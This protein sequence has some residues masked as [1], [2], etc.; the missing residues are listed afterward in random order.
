MSPPTPTASRPPS[1][2][3][4]LLR[5][6]LGSGR[7]PLA[8][9][10]GRESL[11]RG[12]EASLTSPLRRPFRGRGT[13]PERARRTPRSLSSWSRPQ[14]AGSA[15]AAPGSWPIA[16]PVSLASGRFGSARGPSPDR[17]Q[18]DACAATT[19]AALELTGRWACREATEV[20][21]RPDVRRGSGSEE[22][23]PGGRA[24]GGH[25][26]RRRRP[27]SPPG[28]GH[29]RAGA[30][31]PPRQAS[32]GVELRGARTH[33]RFTRNVGSIPHRAEATRAARTTDVAVG[34][35]PIILR[36]ESPSRR[37]LALDPGAS[38]CRRACM[39]GFGPDAVSFG[40]SRLVL[41]HR[42]FRL[43]SPRT[44]RPDSAD[45]CSAFTR[46]L[47]GRAS[48]RSPGSES[49]R[50][51]ELSARPPAVR[52]HRGTSG[53]F[54]RLVAATPS[55]E[56]WGARRPTRSTPGQR[57]TH[58]ASRLESLACGGL[59]RRV[60]RR[61]R[62]AED[63]SKMSG[64]P[65]HRLVSGRQEADPIG[66]HAVWSARRLAPRRTLGLAPRPCTVRRPR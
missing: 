65:A 59:C 14:P 17:S 10:H 64:P 36:E 48:L 12:A 33:A 30:E 38:P 3:S 61:P 52:R 58:A 63:A 23:A 55:V 37:H 9:E 41:E 66:S 7:M 13:R 47:L 29:D 39:T 19:P 21:A 42:R 57:C 35:D 22:P 43:R 50:P 60:V 5:V 31:A 15:I 16:G 6:R 8:G 51:R 45:R 56:G 62:S 26:G 2:R 1:Q 24:S 18:P 27:S 44:G 40:A 54:P 4:A 53:S 49:R 25:R 32:V 11:A 46:D 28:G 34:G 20:S